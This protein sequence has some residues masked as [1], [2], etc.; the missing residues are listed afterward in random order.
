MSTHIMTDIETLGTRPGAVIISAAF[1][2]CSDEA[3]MVLN[4]SIPD[5]TALAMEIDPKTHA[6]WGEQEAKAP[7]IWQRVTE[8]P[9]PIAVALPY[10][11]Q[12]LQWA[13]GGSNDWLIW[14]HGATFDCPLLDELYRRAGIPSPWQY[15]QV[16]DTRTLYDLAG[17]NPKDYAVPPPHIALN[18][19]LGQAR[20]LMASLIILARAH[21]H[22]AA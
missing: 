12:W 1:V 15:W 17:I 14:C 19:A 7:G 18:D 22:Q 4:L 6:W 3:H 8:N 2:R 16:R 11:A 5:Q 21:I 13:A 20:A 10:I 9:Q